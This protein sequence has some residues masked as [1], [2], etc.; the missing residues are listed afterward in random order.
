MPKHPYINRTIILLLLFLGILYTLLF[1]SHYYFSLP[2]YVMTALNFFIF[3]ILAYLAVSIILRLSVDRIIF[4]V[5][6]DM[7]A[8]QKIFFSKV[9]SFLLY[10]FATTL[11]LMRLGFSLDNISLIIGFIATGTAFAV[12]DVIISFII[13]F[14]LLTK[15]PFRIGDYIKIGEEEGKVIHIGTFYVL[16]DETPDSKEDYTRVP[17]KLFLEKPIRNYG[18]K[19]ILCTVRIPIKKIPND[20]YKRISRLHKELSS[21]LHARISLESKETAYLIIVTFRSPYLKKE[22]ASTF[23]IQKISESNHDIFR[24]FS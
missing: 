4:F 7:D 21:S 6:R 15:R 11:V 23:V 16:L 17:N 14:V 24:E 2:E 10:I 22:E 12:R 5:G 3:I 9:Y 8:E 20:I 19:D 13:W 1:I 18:K